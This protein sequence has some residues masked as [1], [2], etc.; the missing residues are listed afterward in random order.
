MRSRLTCASLI[1]GA[2]LTACSSAPA[3]VTPT[4]VL[5]T[6]APMGGAFQTGATP[7]P[8]NRDL[9]TYAVQRGDV[10]NETSVEGQVVEARQRELSFLTGGE[11]AA[12]YM[13]SG[14]TFAQG[15]IVAEL[16]SDD[17]EAQ[18]EDVESAY[19]RAKRELQATRRLEQL[20]IRKAELDLVAAKS[21]L[22]ELRQPP[23]AMAM[24]Q[25]EAAVRQ[26]EADLAQVRNDSSAV[27]SR[28]EL[29]VRLAAQELEAA[30]ERYVRAQNAEVSTPEQREQDL[31]DAAAA[32]RA[33]ENALAQARVELDTARGNELAAI[34]HAEAALAAARADLD[35]LI[36]GPSRFEISAAER[37]VQ[38]AQLTLEEARQRALPNPVVEEQIAAAEK[39]IARIS[40]QLE[41]RKL[42][43]PFD[44]QIVSIIGIPG[45]L[46]RPGEPVLVAVDTSISPA[47]KLVEIAGG[48]DNQ[49]VRLTVGEEVLV[50]FPRY[51]D[52]TFQ[53]TVAET[54]FALP[55]GSGSSRSTTYRITFAPNDVA[56]DAE[57]A[58]VVTI[59]SP[60]HE[61]VLWLPRKAVRIDT[62]NRATVQMMIDG[63]EERVPITIGYVSADRVEIIEGLE[64]GDAVLGQ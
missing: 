45:T 55:N 54:R 27:K 35:L 8:E 62:R 26:A 34:Q 41:Q 52:R 57:D 16:L 53:G 56:L 36:A 13:A 9:V 29:S 11:I 15:D 24:A 49:A 43:A 4:V 38:A 3:A 48:T 23:T 51:R 25:A 30:Q 42:Y 5:P 50:S 31:A 44:G 46:V 7:T 19:N 2:L 12:I 58:A 17:L 6:A 28:A 40:E 22:E 10:A 39:E 33:A 32:L 64:E 59:V 18:L 47:D 37:D 20:P 1:L 63:N 14:E 60:P 21:R 61:D